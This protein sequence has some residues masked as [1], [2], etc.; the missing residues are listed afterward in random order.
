MTYYDISSTFQKH[1]LEHPEIYSA[2]AVAE[3][4]TDRLWREFQ[5]P[6]IEGRDHADWTHWHG[7]VMAPCGAGR[8]L[9]GLKHQTWGV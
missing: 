8:L 4:P 7:L 5:N 2:A 3:V 1:I 9:S 6:R